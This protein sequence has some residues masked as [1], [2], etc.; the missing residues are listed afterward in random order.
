MIKAYISKRYLKEKWENLKF[1]FENILFADDNSGDNV[2]D[3]CIRIR[4]E[5]FDNMDAIR[6]EMED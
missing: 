3:K 4:H 6:K 5:I 1:D 2:S